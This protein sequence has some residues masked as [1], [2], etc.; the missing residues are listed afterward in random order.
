MD[1]E[2]QH[3]S[4]EEIRYIMK[5]AKSLKVSRLLI[6]DFTQA[7]DIKTRDRKS[8]FLNMLLRIL[9][10]NFLGNMLAGKE[11]IRAGDGVQ[12]AGQDF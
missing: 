4:Y 3:L 10:V 9:S 11:V 1:L 5:I 6:K 12:R 2:Q 7:I 8:G